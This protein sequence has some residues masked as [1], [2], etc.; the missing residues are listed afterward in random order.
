MVGA[1]AVSPIYVKK[2]EHY[3]WRE[4]DDE[5]HLEMATNVIFPHIEENESL[6]KVRREVLL[7]PGPATTTDSVKYAQVA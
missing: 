6:R 2:I 4:I 7:N 5:S 3:V 1:S